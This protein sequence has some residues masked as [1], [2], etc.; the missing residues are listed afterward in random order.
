LTSYKGNS[1]M[2]KDGSEP[3]RREKKDGR[4]ERPEG[5]KR[6]RPS[7]LKKTTKALIGMISDRLASRRDRNETEDQD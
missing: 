2:L 5:G 4:K 7:I 6:T 3:C 1:S